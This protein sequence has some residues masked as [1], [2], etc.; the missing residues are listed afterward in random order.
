VMRKLLSIALFAFVL[1]AAALHTQI[2]IS[3]TGTHSSPEDSIDFVITLA[4]AGT[5]GLQTWGFGG[6]LLVLGS[7]YGRRPFAPAE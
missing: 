1:C 5:M 2:A 7:L 6:I 4:I 3:R